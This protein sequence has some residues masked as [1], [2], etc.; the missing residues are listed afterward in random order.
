MWVAAGWGN[1]RHPTE[2][3]PPQCTSTSLIGCHQACRSLS[4]EVPP[5]GIFNKKLCLVGT[6][7]PFLCHT[8][9]FEDFWISPGVIEVS[10][11]DRVLVS[12]EDP[13]SLPHGPQAYC[14]CHQLR[15]AGERKNG[16]RNR[17]R[18]GTE[19]GPPLQEE[20]MQ[21]GRIDSKAG[22]SSLF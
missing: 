17:E 13:G 3:Y 12:L 8:Q 1:W 5:E 21:G 18:K 10:S 15:E 6:P 4:W 2:P 22:P 20:G 9:V 19:D 14:P 16:D 7:K 11:S